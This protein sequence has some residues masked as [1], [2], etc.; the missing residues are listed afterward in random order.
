MKNKSYLLIF[1][2][3]FT[4]L[5]SCKTNNV[6]NKIS[7]E[8]VL[9]TGKKE[10]E[11]YNQEKSKILILKYI[12]NNNPVINFNY[13][14]IDAKTKKELKKGIFIGKKIEWLDNSTLKATPYVGM[15]RQENN[16]IL[17]DKKKEVSQPFT[18]IKIK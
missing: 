17:D 15:I 2:T 14:V 18:I 13:Q 3:I 9:L 1:T 4:L 12:S 16:L 7:R 11:I 5:F 6:Q 8:N 10:I